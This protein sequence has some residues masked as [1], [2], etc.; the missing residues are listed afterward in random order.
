[1]MR[2]TYAARMSGAKA[3]T[4]RRYYNDWKRHAAL[5][6]SEPINWESEPI[7]E[8]IKV[9]NET[10][11]EMPLVTRAVFE[12]LASRSLKSRPSN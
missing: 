3:E 2:G 5:R 1:M 10:V 9:P 6:K 8:T 7:N 4:W 11:N 12:R